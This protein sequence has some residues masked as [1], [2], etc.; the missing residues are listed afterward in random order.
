MVLS[1]N[2]GGPKPPRFCVIVPL[3]LVLEQKGQFVGSRVVKFNYSVRPASRIPLKTCNTL[4]IPTPTPDITPLTIPV[5]LS[6]HPDGS[7]CD[8]DGNPEPDHDEVHVLFE[9][10]QI[11]TDEDMN[12][13]LF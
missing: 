8:K 1:K 10:L 7:R 11:P 2:R 6:E 3:W 9:L 13:S 5:S 4:N 12:K